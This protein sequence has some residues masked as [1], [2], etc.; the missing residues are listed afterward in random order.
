ME[1]V[2][3][4]VSLFVLSIPVG[5]G[6]GRGYYAS[7]RGSSMGDG[8]ATRPWD[9]ATAVAG[10]HGRIQ[11]GDTIWLRGGTYRGS[12]IIT[13]AGRAGAPV[14]FRRFPGERAIIDGASSAKDTWSARGEYTVFWGFELMNSKPLRVSTTTTHRI[15]PDVLANYAAHTKY[16]NLIVHDG[17]VALY[18]DANYPD[19]E[20]AGCIFY[21]NG[22]QEPG[23]RGHGH[24]L[25]IKNYT[26][27]LIARD[28]VAFN[29]Y[30]YG[31]H[32]YTNANSG[33][34][35]NITIEGNVSFNNGSLATRRSLSPNILLGGEGYAAGGTIRDNSTYFS[36]SLTAADANVAVGYKDVRNGDVVVERNYFV[37][38]APVLQFGYWQ[39]ARVSNDTL[40]SWSGRSLI[41]RHDPG[42]A[43]HVWRDNAE[44]EAPPSKTRI[45]VRPNPY[46][47]G[48]AHIVVYNWGKQQRVDVN[49][50]GVLADGDRYEVRNVQDLFGKPVASGTLNG[51]TISIPMDG[52]TPPVPVG[53][54]VSP[55]PKTGPAFD[56]F[57]VTRVPS[58]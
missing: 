1:L 35:I 50:N 26:G 37:G 13:V 46:E 32:A 52:V 8:S 44:L 7:P 30:G 48:R 53:L 55:A 57:L 28:N 6:V 9:L 25:Y 34:L 24:A 38:G 39:G 19:V 12:F 3:L 36:P 45:V 10:G 29:Q 15:R 27:P 49:V 14:V 17:G 58:P 2:F 47:A 40:I 11:P 23:Q 18:T 21:N 54:H 4:F 43:G 22:W 16:I 20:I 42:A 56:T 51:T 41:E 33:K 5:A 31:I